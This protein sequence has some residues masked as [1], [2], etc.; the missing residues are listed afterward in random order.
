MLRFKGYTWKALSVLHI[1]CGNSNQSR[2]VRTVHDGYDEVMFGETVPYDAEQ[3]VITKVF[4]TFLCTV[5]TTYLL[6]N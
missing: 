6:A 1:M 2:H 4:S 3:I 5:G